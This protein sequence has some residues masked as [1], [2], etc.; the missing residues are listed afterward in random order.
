MK[1]ICEPAIDTRSTDP[2]IVRTATVADLRYATE[3]S[4]ETSPWYRN[5]DKN[6]TVN[7]S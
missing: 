1:D 7:L 6:P 5:R 3:I 2:I 4:N